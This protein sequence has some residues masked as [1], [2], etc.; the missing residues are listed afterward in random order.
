TCRSYAAA[1]GSS[2][3]RIVARPGTEPEILS[4]SSSRWTRSD[5]SSA[6]ALPSITVAPMPPP[7]SASGGPFQE[8]GL[9]ED[10]EAELD[11]LLVLR[12]R[13]L[14]R[15]DEVRLLR[16]ARGHARAG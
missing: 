8:R 13:I 16:H 4:C 3:T 1:A 7:A 10:L 14:A 11:R 9:V 12:P 6:R 15:H 5:S 2:P